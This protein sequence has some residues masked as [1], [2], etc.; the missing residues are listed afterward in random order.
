MKLFGF[1]SKTPWKMI[2]ASLGYGIVILAILGG[3]F[4]SEEEP[5]LTDPPQTSEEASLEETTEPTE[6]ISEPEVT[7]EPIE[8]PEIVEE[9]EEVPEV[10]ENVIASLNP[11]EVK[12]TIKEDAKND[13]SDDYSMQEYAIKEQT[14]AYERLTKLSIDEEIKEALLTDAYKSWGSDFTMVEYQ[15]EEQLKALKEVTKI[16]DQLEASSVEMDIMMVAMETWGRDFTMVLY[17]YEE[18]LKAYQNL[19]N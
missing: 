2:L 13:W 17:Q 14:K 7:E 10:P 19:N 11:D 16:Y 6:D 3:L 18:Q 12:A 5:T 1:R 9:P 4:G 8:E 15:Y